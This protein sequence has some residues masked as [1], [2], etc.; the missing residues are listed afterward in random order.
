LC[1]FLYNGFCFVHLLNWR[2]MG[3][4]FLKFEELSLNV[5]LTFF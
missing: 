1:I 5:K 3:C 2:K 4:K